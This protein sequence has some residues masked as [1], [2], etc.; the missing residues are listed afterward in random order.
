[1]QIVLKCVL[2]LGLM[3]SVGCAGGIGN[4]GTR[5]GPVKDPAVRPLPSIA[6]VGID[7]TVPRN[8]LVSEKN[9]FKPSGDIVWHGEAFGDRHNQV[10]AIFQNAAGTALADINGNLPVVIHVVVSKFH[11]VTQRTR[12][13]IGGT[14]AIDFFLSVSNGETGDPIIRPFFVSTNLKAYGGGRAIRAEQAGQTQKVRITAHIAQLIRA[15]LTSRPFN[16]VQP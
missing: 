10:Q 1:M 12:A 3:L 6:V 4:F 9:G 13:T 15:E 14:H 7:V 8:L 5:T 11:G 16:V 2:A